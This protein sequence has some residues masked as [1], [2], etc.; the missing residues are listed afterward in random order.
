MGVKL[1]GVHFHCGSG[2]NGS[3]SFEKAVR[4]ARACIEIGRKYGHTM[5]VMDIGGGF[6]QGELQDHFVKSLTVTKDDPL[7]YRVIAEP[8]RHFCSNSFYLFT[9]VLAKRF[10]KE[11]MCYH[12]ND[13]LY[14]SFNC[15]LMDGVSFEN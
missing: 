15:V 9:R 6:P 10:K 14:H 5:E 1:A 2:P 3:T 8:G 11:K 7:G 4:M 13:S 12:V